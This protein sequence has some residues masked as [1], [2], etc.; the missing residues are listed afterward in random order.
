MSMK[1][2]FI[3]LL[4]VA[5]VGVLI[6]V[7]RGDTDQDITVPVENG[8]IATDEGD[9]EVVRVE[10]YGF[11]LTHEGGAEGYTYVVNE[12]SVRGD[13]VYGADIFDA[14]EYDAFV[15]TQQGGESPVSL[16]IAVYRNPMNLEIREWIESTDASN[17][18]LSVDNTLE[19]VRMGDTQFVTY[20]IDGLYR[21]DVYAFAQ[22]G[23]VY[24]FANQWMESDSVMR[25]DMEGV[26]SSLDFVTPATPASS[27]HGD[28]VVASPMP[29]DTVQ[30][31][32][33]ISGEARGFWFFEASFP[34]VL[35]DWDG[36]IIAEGIATAQ[37]D[38][39]TEEFVPFT[40]ELPYADSAVPTFN[41]KGA[42]ILKRDNPSGLPENDDAIEIPLILE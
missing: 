12:E 5:L 21:S 41:A 34:V 16:S 42:L 7:L 29:G 1:N 31:P 38:W 28:I 14:Q 36:R 40:A 26:I 15:T 11:T 4:C 30:S 37:G 8:D 25:T 10:E 27:A 17:F 32:L 22:E 19:D 35:V 33:A 13:Q 9:T 6:F 39:M 23:Y 24:L 18:S 20:T 2:I 3:I